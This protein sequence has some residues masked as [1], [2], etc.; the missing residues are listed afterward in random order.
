MGILDQIISAISS[1][2]GQQKPPSNVYERTYSTTAGVGVT[3]TNIPRSTPGPNS[4]KPRPVVHRSIDQQGRGGHVDPTDFA[5]GFSVQGYSTQQLIAL[6]RR[7][8]PRGFVPHNIAQEGQVKEV[9]GRKYIRVK[10]SDP[11]GRHGSTTE[12][13]RI[14]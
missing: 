1:L 11:S 10:Y 3:T 5:R 14:S 7:Q 9:G 12:D 13:V 8:A 4:N 2:F 6:A